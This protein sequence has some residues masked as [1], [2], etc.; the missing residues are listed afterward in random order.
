MNHFYD[1]AAATKSLQEI[2][3]NSTKAF[4]GNKDR[5]R[6]HLSL[7]NADNLAV[8]MTGVERRLWRVGPLEANGKVE[9]EFIFQ[10]Q[11][12][13]SKVALTAPDVGRLSPPQVKN[14][15]QQII[16]VS[17]GCQAFNNV[18]VNLTE[19]HSLYSRH[20]PKNALLPW[21]G[22]D[23]GKTPQMNASM[24]FFTNLEDKPSAIHIPISGNIDLQGV[25]QKF[26]G[27]ELV[28]TS[29]NVIEYF[30]R[31]KDVTSGEYIYDRAVPSTF[32]VGDIVDIESSVIVFE[33]R[34][35]QIKMHCTLGGL[36]T[37]HHHHLGEGETLRAP[38]RRSTRR[39]MQHAP[40]REPKRSLLAE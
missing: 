1:T 24:Q 20:F 17:L 30:K 31:G 22:S 3:A 19:L 11:G 32:R 38:P 7:L 12:V 26:I 23:V 2:I 39:G 40:S 27:A 16:I 5:G 15:S 14:M 4:E 29:E 18:M 9:E 37:S 36:V 34:Q 25:L 21:E 6:Q 8:Q 13:L 35:N 28:H 10:M 33:T